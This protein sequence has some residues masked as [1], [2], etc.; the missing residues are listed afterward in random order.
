MGS[1]I[2]P[3]GIKAMPLVAGRANHSAN[4]AD[5]FVRQIS[6]AGKT[7]HAI[8]EQIRVFGFASREFFKRA[9]AMQTATP[10]TTRANAPGTQGALRGVCVVRRNDD[11]RSD[12]T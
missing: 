10:P 11:G 4:F 6:P 1:F 5:R 7:D 12:P 9:M 8:D 2:A 3:E